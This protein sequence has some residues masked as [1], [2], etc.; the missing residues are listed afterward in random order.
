MGIYISLQTFLEQETPIGRKIEY[1]FVFK[2]EDIEYN[3]Q[4]SRFDDF[5]CYRRMRRTR[6]GFGNFSNFDWNWRIG[7]LSCIW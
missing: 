4:G 5:I 2:S 7:D 3:L 1:N 6:H